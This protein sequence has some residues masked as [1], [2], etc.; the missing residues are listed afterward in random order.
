[1]ALSQLSQALN[2]L[3]VAVDAALDDPTTSW[4]ELA[5]ARTTLSTTVSRINQ[6]RN[7]LTPVGR[8]PPETLG[9]IFEFVVTPDRNIYEPSTTYSMLAHDLTVVCKSWRTTAL[10]WPR[11]WY[12]IIDADMGSAYAWNPKT[13]FDRSNTTPLHI[14]SQIPSQT[15][16][17]FAHIY[18]SHPHRI[19]EAHLL[20]IDEYHP[21]VI[22]RSLASP[23]PNLKFMNLSGLRSRTYQLEAGM[24]LILGGT[25]TSLRAFALKQVSFVP[26][27]SFPNLIDLRLDT[28]TC[29]DWEFFRLLRNCPRLETLELAHTET[30]LSTPLQSSASSGSVLDLVSGGDKPIMSPVVLRHLRGLRM[31]YMKVVYAL[32]ILALLKLP[33]HP[34]MRLDNLTC[35]SRYAVLPDWHEVWQSRVEPPLSTLYEVKG[36]THLDIIHVREDNNAHLHFISHGQNCGIWVHV[37]AIDPGPFFHLVAHLDTRAIT[38]FRLSVPHNAVERLSFLR[39]VLVRMPSLSR[40]LVKCRVR[41]PAQSGTALL[42]EVAGALTPSSSS[43]NEG[44]TAE[45]PVPGLDYFGIEMDCARIPLDALVHMA[46]SRKRSAHPIRS[47]VCNISGCTREDLLPLSEFVDAYYVATGFLFEVGPDVPSVFKM[48]ND[49]WELFRREDGMTSWNM[50]EE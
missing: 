1:M 41:L 12:H 20:N 31:G 28:M 36:H 39:F 30:L 33:R 27:N 23:M 19:G 25:S 9:R 34:V 37:R 6:H 3:N 11:M 43:S 46:A 26:G 8:L 40:L 21:M 14:Y 15:G 42:K 22:L 38:T 18:G 7:R 16:S 48:K 2:E 5:H 35:Y 45:I 49:Y 32:A 29:V 24:P 44:G 4:D 50:P 13:V 10:N 47:L 17:M